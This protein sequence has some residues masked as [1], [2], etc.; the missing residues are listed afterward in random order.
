M[1]YLRLVSL[2]F[3]SLAFG[4][5]YIIVSYIHKELSQNPNPTCHKDIN[6]RGLVFFFV[7]VVKHFE[8]KWFTSA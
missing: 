8:E 2:S 1:Y 4:E 3:S 6:L 5:V 7:E